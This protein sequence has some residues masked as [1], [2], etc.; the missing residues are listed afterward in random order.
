MCIIYVM[1]LVNELSLS[2]CGHEPEIV[3]DFSENFHGF[4]CNLVGKY[5][6]KVVLV[7]DSNSAK[8]LL[9]LVNF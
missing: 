8:Q 1:Y 5:C 2:Q 4:L 7:R 3:R 6:N 9:T